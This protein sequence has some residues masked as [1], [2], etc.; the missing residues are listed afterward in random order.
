MAQLG[1]RVVMHL[2]NLTNASSAN[3]RD[4]LGNQRE[5]DSIQ[6]IP[7][8]VST[9]REIN[10]I[11]MASPDYNNGLPVSIEFKQSV[12]DVNFNIPYLK[13]WTVVVIEYKEKSVGIKYDK[14][15]SPDSKGLY[16]NCYP[17]PFNSSTMINFNLK[18]SSKVKIEIF[19]A[20]GRK[21][22]DLAGGEAD[23]GHHLL[24]WAANSMPSGLYFCRVSTIYETQII[25][26]LLVK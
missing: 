14:I 18:K 13:Y 20:L 5:P 17:N 1:S 7:L 22:N 19:D 3:W 16:L 21:I 24:A 2:I 11:W 6:N 26:I 23:A 10:R 8:T 25:K 4:D 15:N 12:S 9:I